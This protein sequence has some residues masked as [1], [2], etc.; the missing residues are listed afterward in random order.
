MLPIILIAAL[1]LIAIGLFVASRFAP[2]KDGYGDP[3]RKWWTL[4]AAGGLVATLIVTALFS[5][6][7]V[8]PRTVGVVVAFGDR[9]SV[10]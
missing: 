4:G 3:I 7:I 9:K 8:Q 2:K 10:V 6:V 5:F 1:A